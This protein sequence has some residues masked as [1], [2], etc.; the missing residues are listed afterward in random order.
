MS[1]ILNA[2]LGSFPN[3]F[4][5]NLILTLLGAAITAWTATFFALHGFRMQNWREMN[6]RKYQELISLPSEIELTP[7]GIFRP[8]L[9]AR[10]ITANQERKMD[11]SVRDLKVET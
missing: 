10:K 9:G 4:I 5:E 2:L 3:G 11:H 1:D 8:E 7:E 6:V